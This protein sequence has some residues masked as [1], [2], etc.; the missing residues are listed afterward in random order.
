M[1]NA[2]QERILELVGLIYEAAGDPSRWPAFLDR[3]A[4]TIGSNEAFFL[5]HDLSRR[6]A[7]FAIDTRVHP[8][9][10]RLYAEY[11]GGMNQWIVNGPHLLETGVIIVGSMM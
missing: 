2:S 7:S 11:Y 10:K 3:W 5:V 1:I 8:D 4:E 6:E 9:Y